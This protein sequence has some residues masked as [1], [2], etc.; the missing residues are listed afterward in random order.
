MIEEMSWV[1]TD[2]ENINNHIIN[3]TDKYLRKSLSNN[4][5]QKNVS[6]ME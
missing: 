1:K 4:A 5:L 3:D 2:Q 6:C